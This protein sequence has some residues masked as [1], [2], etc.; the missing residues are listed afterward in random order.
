M[1]ILLQPEA[2]TI[3]NDKLAKNQEFLLG[4]LT[5]VSPFKLMKAERKKLKT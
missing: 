5:R 3:S 4:I 1:K 2:K